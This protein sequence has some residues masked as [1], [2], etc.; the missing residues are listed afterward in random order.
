M[1]FPGSSLEM[2][3]TVRVPAESTRLW[4]PGTLEGEPSSSRASPEF[5]VQSPR[6]RS[7][8]TVASHVLE[9]PSVWRVRLRPIDAS[10]TFPTSLSAETNLKKQGLLPLTFS[11]PSDYDKIRPDDKVSITGLQTFAPGKVSLQLS[12]Q[13]DSGGDDT[14]MY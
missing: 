5:T 11:N 14:D 4:S 12:P 8:R 3:T 1:V 9:W 6:V 2:T 7:G 10:S 13:R